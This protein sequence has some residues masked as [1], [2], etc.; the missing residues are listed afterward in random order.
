[1]SKR[2]ISYWLAAIPWIVFF[3]LRLGLMF[4]LSEMV[5][6][7]MFFLYSMIHQFFLL[8]VIIWSVLLVHIGHLYARIAL[9]ES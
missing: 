7:Q 1:M 2:A 9:Y 5:E 8:P 3:G 4:P 6:M